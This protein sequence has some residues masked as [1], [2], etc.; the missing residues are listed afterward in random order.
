MLAWMGVST[1]QA[2]FSPTVTTSWLVSDGFVTVSALNHWSQVNFGHSRL[3]RFSD[4]TAT[5]KDGNDTDIN[6]LLFVQFYTVGDLLIEDQWT[7]YLLSLSMVVSIKC[8]CT[9]LWTQWMPYWWSLMNSAHSPNTY[10]IYAYIYIYI[11]H[12]HLFLISPV[13]FRTHAIL[14][15]TRELAVHT[16]PPCTHHLPG[17]RVGPGVVEEHTGA[18]GDFTTYF[19]ARA[20]ARSSQVK[21]S[22]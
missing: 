3:Y 9:T 22:S 17:R 10:I 1:G 15:M 19:G 7:C 21:I 6:T 18:N 14:T 8:W 16:R 13:F 4:T 12:C 20:A 5:A 2:F 11:R